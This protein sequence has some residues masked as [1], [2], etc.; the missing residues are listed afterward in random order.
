MKPTL[1]RRQ[2]LASTALTASALAFPLARVRAAD[3]RPGDFIF[4]DKNEN[5]HGI[6]KK[7]EDAI[8]GSL[9]ASNRY[10]L[11]EMAALRDL[12]AAREKVSSDCVMM[13]VGCTEIF[14]LACLRY[15]ADGKEVL[16]ADRKSVV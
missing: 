5:P 15:G 3:S 14:C 8:A 7:V 10:P 9:R 13:G 4:L 6:T 2:W 12:I 16:A 11:R 1:N